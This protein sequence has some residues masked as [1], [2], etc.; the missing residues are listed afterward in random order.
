MLAIRDGS[1]YALYQYTPQLVPAIIAAGLFAIGGVAHIIL[2]RRLRTK[3]FV[4]FAVGCFSKPCNFLSF[5]LITE[6]LTYLV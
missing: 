5:H 1:A 4:P 3:Y 2:L 6:K